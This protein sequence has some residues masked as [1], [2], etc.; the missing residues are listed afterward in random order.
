MSSDNLLGEV[1]GLSTLDAEEELAGPSLNLI[2]RHDEA[3]SVTELGGS[4]AGQRVKLSW[5]TPDMMWPQVR[6]PMI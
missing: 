2:L 6:I 1:C 5:L 3:T 4:P